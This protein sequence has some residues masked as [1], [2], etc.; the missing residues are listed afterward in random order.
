MALEDYDINSDL[1]AGHEEG[2]GEEEYDD[3]WK[4]KYQITSKFSHRI[5]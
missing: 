2:E 4:D 1:E 3:Y 5:E